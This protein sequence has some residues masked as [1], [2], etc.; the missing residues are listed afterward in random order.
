MFSSI[1]GTLRGSEKLEEDIR[2][3][4]RNL[5]V[6]HQIGRGDIKLYLHQQLSDCEI[7]K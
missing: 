5:G 6:K 4:A 7:V 1:H 3:R 2:E